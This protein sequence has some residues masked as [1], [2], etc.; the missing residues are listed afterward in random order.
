MDEELDEFG[1]PVKQQVDEFGIPIKKNLQIANRKYVEGDIKGST[2]EKAAPHIQHIFNVNSATKRYTNATKAKGEQVVAKL[3]DF[4]TQRSKELQAGIKTEADLERA[5]ETFKQEIGVLQNK[6]VEEAEFEVKPVFEELAALKQS[7]LENKE[8][9]DRF[10]KEYQAQK[11]REKITP[12]LKI[13]GVGNLLTNIGV[14]AGDILPGGVASG[15]AGS[16][17]LDYDEEILRD[18]KARYNSAGRY[19]NARFK[20]T[21]EEAA[22]EA[23]QLARKTSLLDYAK[24]QH[25]E[26]EASTSDF[27]KTW[28]EAKAGG[29]SGIGSYVLKNTGQSLGLAA[30]TLVASAVNPYLGGAVGYAAMAGL[31]KGEAFELG[32]SKLEESTGL[33]RDE[34]FKQNLDATLRETSTRSGAINGLL[35]YIGTMSAVGKL[36]PKNVIT[37]LL[38]KAVKNKALNAAGELTLGTTVNGITEW[39]QAKNTN[40]AALQGDGYS[41]ITLKTL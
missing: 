25:I 29:F 10:A 37:N 38:E 1:I 11:M 8:Y 13:P 7:P 36:V 14:G 5:R 34:I 41:F 22:Y 30:P 20:Q 27:P 32:V 9:R 39:L 4:A 23:N 40:I 18:A 15:T 3:T 28:E 19:S 17:S 33:S 26:A 6:L 21:K 31:E 12:M 16:I 35:E 24:G 2:E